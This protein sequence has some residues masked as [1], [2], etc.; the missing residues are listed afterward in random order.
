MLHERH[1]YYWIHNAALSW[2]S[3]EAECQ[4]YKYGHLASV[5]DQQE[6]DFLIDIMIRYGKDY[7]N[8]F[9]TVNC[10]QEPALGSSLGGD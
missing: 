5:H 10:P 3:A 1:C 7:K 6:M 8:L 4:L 9:V 2:Q